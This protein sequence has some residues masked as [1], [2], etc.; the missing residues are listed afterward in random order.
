MFLYK[1]E[2]LLAII[3]VYLFVYEIYKRIEETVASY[4]QM[5]KR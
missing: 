4:L 5:H 2:N 1:W 3:G